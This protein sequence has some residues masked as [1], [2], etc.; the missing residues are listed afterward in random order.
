MC[1]VLLVLVSAVRKVFAANDVGRDVVTRPLPWQ[2][3][4]NQPT[5][6]GRFLMAMPQFR[7]QTFPVD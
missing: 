1:A 6:S 4:E 2:R 7:R 3:R 5:V